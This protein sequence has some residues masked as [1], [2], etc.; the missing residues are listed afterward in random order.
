MATFVYVTSEKS[1]RTIRR[2]GI[3]A[4]PMPAAIPSGVYAMPVVAAS[5]E[6]YT[7]Q[8]ELHHKGQRN[9]CGVYFQ[10]PDDEVVWISLYNEPHYPTT[11]AEVLS[12]LTER[13]VNNDFKVII[14]RSILKSEIRQIR[15][16]PQ[17][18]WPSYPNPLLNYSGL[19]KP[20]AEAAY[21]HPR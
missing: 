5:Y 11:A 6:T 2:C 12:L 9:F 21:A 19:G 15:Y 14:P 7:W 20:A 8:Q 10:I 4:K 3:A 13:L 17:G 18:T 16:V 1:V